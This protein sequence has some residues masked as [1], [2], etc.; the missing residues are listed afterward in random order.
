MHATAVR[1]RYMADSVQTTS[2]ARLVT[3]LYDA[4]VADLDRAVAALAA[5]DLEAVNGRL[6]HAQD[7]VSE[8]LA[9]LDVGAWDGGPALAALYEFLL[10]ELIGAN[11]AKDGARMLACRELVEPLRAAWHAAAGGASS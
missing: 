11:V 6:V 8:L 10:R 3:M 1:N 7:I 9:S 5:R 2:P 4:L